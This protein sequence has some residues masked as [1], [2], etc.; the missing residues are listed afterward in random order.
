MYSSTASK[1]LL[2]IADSAWPE[3]APIEKLAHTLGFEAVVSTEIEGLARQKNL[4]V[5]VTKLRP[6]SSLQCMIESMRA[7]AE[8][9]Q[10]VIRADASRFAGGDNT[11]ESSWSLAS[12]MKQISPKRRGNRFLMRS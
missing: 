5:V 10:F 6:G 12:L 1:R 9:V 11:R 4:G 2:G 8:D 7:F 3:S